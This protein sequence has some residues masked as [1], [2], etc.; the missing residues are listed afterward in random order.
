MKEEIIKRNH[1]FVDTLVEYY[2]CFKKWPTTIPKVMYKGVNIS[3]ALAQIKYR[4]TPLSKEDI[5]RLKK[6]KFPFDTAPIIHNKV[7]KLTDYFAKNKCWPTNGMIIYENVDIGTFFCE[8][9]DD[10][11]PLT[12]SEIALLVHFRFPFKKK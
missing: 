10:Y 5:S 4:K 11:V 3:Y 9:Q 6:L 7:L 2:N 12:K 8:I 1:N